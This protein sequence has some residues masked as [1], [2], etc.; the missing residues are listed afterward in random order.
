MAI[1]LRRFV[2]R[3]LLTVLPLLPAGKVVACVADCDGDGRVEIAELVLSVS[4]ALGARP[5]AD[6]PQADVDSGGTV[7]I[8]ELVSAVGAALEDTCAPAAC[9]PFPVLESQDESLIQGPGMARRPNGEYAIAWART[10]TSFPN[11]QI[12]GIVHAHLQGS[13]YVQRFDADGTPHGQVMHLDRDTGVSEPHIAYD[14]A[15][16]VVAA[17]GE[18]NGIEA[19]GTVIYESAAAVA[20]APSG[21]PVK[22]PEVILQRSRAEGIV[23]GGFGGIAENARGEVAVA[24]PGTRSVTDPVTVLPP[25]VQRLGADATT[26]G[27]PISLTTGFTPRIAI[28]G[29]GTAAIVIDDSVADDRFAS[30]LRLD[31]IPKSGQVATS[32]ILASV[33]NSY[34]GDHDIAFGSD[35]R[36]VVAWVQRPEAPHDPGVGE[37]AYVRLIDLNRAEIGEPLLAAALPGYGYSKVRVAMA[38][39]G[40]FVVLAGSMARRFTAAGVPAAAFPVGDSLEYPLFPSAPRSVTLDDRGTLV[41]AW[42]DPNGSWIDAQRFRWLCAMRANVPAHLPLPLRRRCRRRVR[43]Q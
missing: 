5:L 11:D 40:D 25:V 24:F 2:A 30:V 3:V 15:G 42:R 7:A 21:K 14:A 12:H 22:P 38:S 29:D 35:G 16:R 9:E 1:E 39:G 19:G 27:G 6:C 17:W 36:G 34:L 43:V 20:F 28:G 10:R 23:W 41:V 37:V 26:R 32:T 33:T 18:G 8:S 4:I 13:L 31:V